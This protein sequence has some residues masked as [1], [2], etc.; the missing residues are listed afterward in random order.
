MRVGLQCLIALKLCWRT[1][2]LTCQQSLL[3][4]HEQALLKRQYKT[5]PRN[6]IIWFDGFKWRMGI[7]S[8]LI[9]RWQGWR[10]K[11]K[12]GVLFYHKIFLEPEVVTTGFLAQRKKLPNISTLN[13]ISLMSTNEV[14][15]TPGPPLSLCPCLSHLRT[16]PFV[17]STYI[18]PA[19]ALASSSWIIFS[20]QSAW[21]F[22]AGMV[23]LLISILSLSQSEGKV[24][25]AETDGGEVC[26]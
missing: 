13:D 26:A 22:G 20:F 15:S 9:P 4:L 18:L 7:W 25:R 21:V 3:S 19:F 16:L 11:Q 24:K 1:L 8:C 23:N 12:W 14:M 5:L 17:I 2:T 6:T 10:I